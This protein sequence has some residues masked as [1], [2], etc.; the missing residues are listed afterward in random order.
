MILHMSQFCDENMEYPKK[1][2]KLQRLMIRDKR[3]WAPDKAISYHV[4]IEFCY[5]YHFKK[6]FSAD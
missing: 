4:V 2:W 1:V 5:F 3:H 6:E